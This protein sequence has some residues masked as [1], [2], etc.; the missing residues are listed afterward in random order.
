MVEETVQLSH[1]AQEVDDGIVRSVNNESNISDINEELKTVLKNPTGNN[2]VYGR[3]KEGDIYSWQEINGGNIGAV[4]AN[5]VSYSTA[6]DKSDGIGKA[7][8]DLGVSLG[9]YV[10]DIPTSTDLSK[11]YVR[12]YNGT[13]RDWE[14]ISSRLPMGID[15][16]PSPALGIDTYCPTSLAVKEYVKNELG[17][18]KITTQQIT[19]GP[20]TRNFDASS[21]DNGASNCT[22]K[23]IQCPVSDMQGDRL[24][25]VSLTRENNT[26]WTTDITTYMILLKKSGEDWVKVAVSAPT[27]TSATEMVTTYNF[28]S[29][30]VLNMTGNFYLMLSRSEEA[31]YN[32]GD[33]L[34]IR[35]S[36]NP[37]GSEHSWVGSGIYFNTDGRIHEEWTP[38]IEIT[39]EHY[40]PFVFPGVVT[41][42][43]DSFG[44][45]NILVSEI[46]NDFFNN[47]ADRGGFAEGRMTYAKGIAAHAEGL[48]HGH[49]MRRDRNGHSY[50]SGAIGDYS[51]CEGGSYTD[52]GSG[53]VFVTNSAL[54][55]GS[56]A[57]G[58]GTWAYG[59]YSHAEGGSAEAVGEGSHAEGYGACALGNYSHAEGFLTAAIATY[60]HAEGQLNHSTQD[61]VH[62][63]GIGYVGS[64]GIPVNVSAHEIM[65]NGD[66]YIYGI[67]GYDGTTTT[68][69]RTAQDIINASDAITRMI[70]NSDNLRYM[71]NRARLDDEFDDIVRLS[72]KSSSAIKNDDTQVTFADALGLFTYHS[73][74]KDI[75]HITYSGDTSHYLSLSTS[76]RSNSLDRLFYRDSNM[77]SSN[78]AYS[79]LIKELEYLDCSAATSMCSTF[80]CSMV[81]RIEK[82]LPTTNMTAAT[83]MFYYETGK[84]V[85]GRSISDDLTYLAGFDCSSLTEYCNFRPGWSGNWHPLVDAFRGR[86][87]ITNLPIFRNLQ[88]SIRDGGTKYGND[89]NASASI[90]Q[91][92]LMA[93]MLGPNDTRSEADKI[94]NV[95]D[96]FDSLGTASLR[97]VN[98][99]TGA[100][101]PNGVGVINFHPDVF[102][103][104]ENYVNTNS[105]VRMALKYAMTKKN[106]RFSKN[107]EQT[108]RKYLNFE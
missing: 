84:T 22:G 2:G 74:G 49:V 33:W 17:D 89:Y 83:G 96:F 23:F 9:S 41:N 12:K 8:Y 97:L 46:H 13:N 30:P 44:D 54:G 67:G 65:S 14:D 108:S 56:H 60:S 82:I 3:K 45:S 81:T 100:Y 88:I 40:E 15:F 39:F 71:F 4:P 31:P 90:T 59:K 79:A 77:V 26:D 21:K 18:L 91:F 55:E 63:V 10:R 11:A 103:R 57:E 6:T 107:I 104:I 37:A 38:R 27:T 95:I 58:G 42:T 66:H 32:I 99:T 105:E 69:V 98:P 106:W 24:I 64:D 101:D 93:N 47:A 53:A 86:Q 29:K 1:T 35:L 61:T 85:D 92:Y 50:Y 73:T 5:I 51:H 52:I 80:E 7:V 102:D 25:R 76:K 75:K 72:K 87:R 68:D 48:G 78:Y 70:K 94:Q 43:Y 34:N 19:Y 36:V 28:L 20:K 62:S 16:R